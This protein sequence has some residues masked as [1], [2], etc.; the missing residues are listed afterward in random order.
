MKNNPHKPGRVREKRAPY[1]R[2]T[3]AKAPQPVTLHGKPV[4][5]DVLQFCEREGVLEYLRLAD[6]LIARHFPDAELLDIAVAE[7]P[8]TA[9]NAVVID[10]GVNASPEELLVR[11]DAFT[12]SWV[13]RVPWPH[14]AKIIPCVYP[15]RGHNGSTRLQ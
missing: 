2:A 7:D 13:D 15:T 6:E 9:E 11:E 4:P 5:D 8:E 10:L 3:R 12:R 14:S 1:A